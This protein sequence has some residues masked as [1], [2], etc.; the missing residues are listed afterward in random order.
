MFAAFFKSCCL[1]VTISLMSLDDL[2]WAHL[3]KAFSPEHTAWGRGKCWHLAACKQKKMLTPTELPLCCDEER[4]NENRCDWMETEL[5]RDRK[6]WLVRACEQSTIR[7]QSWAR[8]RGRGREDLRHMLL[9]TSVMTI[10]NKVLIIHGFV[11][12]SIG[13]TSADGW[14]PLR[15]STICQSVLY[16]QWLH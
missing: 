16:Y 13:H 7:L 15:V 10:T 8:E 14:W 1:K 3:T 2:L 4:A 9:A 12:K 5:W 11:Y 6:G